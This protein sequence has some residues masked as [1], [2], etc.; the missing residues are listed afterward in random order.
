MG[1][2]RETNREG[3]FLGECVKHLPK[4]VPVPRPRGSVIGKD[5]IM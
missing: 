4:P 3:Y 5:V 1:R 2:N